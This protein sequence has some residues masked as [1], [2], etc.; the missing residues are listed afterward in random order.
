MNDDG[1]ESGLPIASPPFDA[2]EGGDTG[3]VGGVVLAAGTSDRFGAENKLLAT[4]DG[5]QIVRRAVRTL[6][7]A[8]IAPV[9]VV[10]GHEADAIRGALRGLDVETVRNESYASGQASSVRAGIEVLEREHDVEAAVIALGDMPFVDPET[11]ETLV[12]AY[13]NEVGDALAAATGG[14]R[15]N[16]VLF[17]RRFFA[18]LTAIGG[19][20]GGRRI[21]LESDASALVE[22]DD[23]G[24]RRDIDESSDLQN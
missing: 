15:G 1:V 23:D 16:P 18:E 21:L 20:T 8:G 17:D 5:E 12:S 7:S 10:I 22:V 6:V 19:D 3:S 2:G 24:V 11:V 4:V 14:K 9:V 13:R